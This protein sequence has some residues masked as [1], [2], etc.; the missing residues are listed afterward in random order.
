MWPHLKNYLT[1]FNLFVK[2]AGWKFNFHL[3]KE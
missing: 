1:D 3:D 2:G